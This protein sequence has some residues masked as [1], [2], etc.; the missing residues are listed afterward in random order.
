MVRAKKSESDR[1]SELEMQILSVLWNNGPQTVRQVLD[2]MPDGKARAY[3]TILS[4]MQSMAK[5]GL[6]QKQGKDGTAHVFVATRSQDAVLK[7]MIG[8]MVEHFFLG[9]RHAMVQM[10]FDG[11]VGQEEMDQIKAILNKEST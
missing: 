2:S 9:N 5:K 10:L 8:Q 11:E 7:P 3:T 4:M 6:I 1:P